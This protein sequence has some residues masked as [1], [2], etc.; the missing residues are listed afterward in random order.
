MY[1]YIITI[2]FTANIIASQTVIFNNQTDKKVLI[3]LTNISNDEYTY[4]LAPKSDFNHDLKLK[5]DSRSTIF[6]KSYF[7]RNLNL[8]GYKKGSE[9]TA[10]KTFDLNNI[11]SFIQN[12]GTRLRFP[13]LDIVEQDGKVTV[14]PQ[15]QE[16]KKIKFT[17]T[18]STPVVLKFQDK[19]GTR[20]K[21]SMLTLT[22]QNSFSTT[23]NSDPYGKFLANFSIISDDKTNE[24]TA[25]DI[26][27]INDDIQR[28][29]NPSF[30]ISYH[31]G[32]FSLTQIKK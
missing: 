3:K 8:R 14:I 16:S 15:A 5:L 21:T 2:I 10:L 18:S 13:I 9:K 12:T 24:L 22:N 32:N 30:Q 1:K 20:Y 25:N 4:T 7:I 6:G 31:N 28:S 26:D 11:N 29:S 27:Q 19:H 17:N 23:I